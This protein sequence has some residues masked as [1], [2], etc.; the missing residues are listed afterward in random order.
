MRMSKEQL[1]VK[2]RMWAEID[3]D[4]GIAEVRYKYTL[5]KIDSDLVVEL[6]RMFFETLCDEISTLEGVE[7]LLSRK[8]NDENDTAAD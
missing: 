7:K 3:D 5:P 1:F 2:L 6:Y 8:E 4:G